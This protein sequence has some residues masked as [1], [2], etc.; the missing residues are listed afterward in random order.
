[1]STDRRELQELQ[2]KL[3]DAG[4]VCTFARETEDGPITG[5]FF[6]NRWHDPLSF[7]ELARSILPWWKGSPTYLQ[8]GGSPAE[9]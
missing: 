9:H 1:M 4:Q 7:A 2:R 8:P 6:C 5:V 3:R